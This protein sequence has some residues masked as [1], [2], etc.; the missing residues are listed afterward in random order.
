MAD[1]AA[2]HTRVQLRDATVADAPLLRRWD[3]E[4]HVIAS[5]PDGHWDWETEL[6]RRPA[7][8]EQLVAEIGGRPIGVVQIIDPLLEETHY[9]DEVPPDLRAIDLWIGEADALGRGYGSQMMQ[10]ALDRCFA[11]GRVTAVLIDPLASNTR[12]HRFYQRFGFCFVER[13]RFN[14]D[15]CFVYRL[16]RTDHAMQATRARGATA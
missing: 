11:D 4:P 13:R 16:T 8:R 3:D 2:H 12:A 14:D 15:D 6:A 9:W 5:D 10:L 1:S 7:W